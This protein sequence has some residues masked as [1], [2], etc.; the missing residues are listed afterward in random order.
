MKKLFTLSV[1]MVAMFTSLT[2]AQESFYDFTMND[3]DGHAVSMKAYE[4]K[5]VARYEPM[6]TPEEIEAE[7]EKLLGQ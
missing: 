7:I 2:W 4:G 1:L 5:V 6:V 3:L